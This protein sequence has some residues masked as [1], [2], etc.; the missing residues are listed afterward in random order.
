MNRDHL[1]AHQTHTED[2]WRLALDVL[3]AHIN[4]AFQTQQGA[5]ERRSD[6][7]LDRRRFQ[8]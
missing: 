1:S 3:S 2:V 4:T 8:R 6:A 7:V 5:G